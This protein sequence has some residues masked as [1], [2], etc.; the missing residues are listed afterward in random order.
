MSL[1]NPQTRGGHVPD[2]AGAPWDCVE[3]PAARGGSPCRLMEPTTPACHMLPSPSVPPSLLCPLPPAA[4]RAGGTWP[5]QGGHTANRGWRGARSSEPLL[6]LLPHCMALSGEGF[7]RKQAKPSCLGGVEAAQ[8]RSKCWEHG[9]QTP[10]QGTFTKRESERRSRLQ[11][12]VSPAPSPTRTHKM[13]GLEG[14]EDKGS[15]LGKPPTPAGEA[16]HKLPSRLSTEQRAEG[17]N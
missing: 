5:G 2:S 13:S 8:P 11:L 14:P 15:V 4:G 1:E 6:A 7:C 12:R 10:S 9:L 16:P 17:L 3:L